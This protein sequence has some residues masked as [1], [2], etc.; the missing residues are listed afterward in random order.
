MN[1]IAS[2]LAIVDCQR[3][4]Q[5]ASTSNL[6]SRSLGALE[7]YCKTWRGDTK[8]LDYQ[9]PFRPSDPHLTHGTSAKSTSMVHRFSACLR[10]SRVLCL[11]NIPP[12]VSFKRSVAED[13]QRHRWH[14]LRSRYLSKKGLPSTLR[15]TALVPAVFHPRAPRGSSFT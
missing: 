4:K 15:P 3:T 9:S 2:S 12:P 1:T 14:A 11:S 7:H 13:G 10:R 6:S 5:A 8:R